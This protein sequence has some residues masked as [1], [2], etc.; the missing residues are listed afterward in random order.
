MAYPLPPSLPPMEARQVDA[1]P[2][3]PGW[4][5]EPKWDGFRCLAFR[6]GGALELRSKSGLPLARYFPEIVAGLLAL[7]AARFVLDGELVVPV[8]R[9]TSFAALQQ[10]LHPAES[11]VRRLAR[12]TPARY[13]VFD[14]LAAGRAAMT[15]RPLSERRGALERF[16]AANLTRAG[17]VRLSPASRHR[18]DA[19]RWLARASEGR[20]GVMAKRL[21]SPYR[22]GDRSG[23]VKIKRVR[24]IDCVVGGFRYGTGSP[25]VGSLL[26]GL[27]DDAGLLH[28]VGFT[29]AIPR[30]ERPA[31]TARLERLVRSPGFTGAAPGGPS[32]WSP[33]RSHE[34]RPLRPELVVEVQTDHVSSRRLRHG[35]MLVRWRPDKRPD[36]CRMEQVL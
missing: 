8:G 3:G 34:W 17:A 31:L 6:D 23:M 4:L 29:S 14:L 2:D 1:V 20:D 36:Q 21:D 13:L 24:T 32:R 26:L 12:E 19:V 9:A 27:Y 18:R 25:L 10:R 7:G 30:A 11:R 5:Y 22:S 16:A 15:A 35:A 33:E 28:H